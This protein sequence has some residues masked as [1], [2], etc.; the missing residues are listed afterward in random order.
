MAKRTAFAVLVILIWPAVVRAQASSQSA[1][2]LSAP[3]SYAEAL[4]VLDRLQKQ[5]LPPPHVRDVQQNRPLCL[6][7]LGRTDEAAAAGPALG[8]PGLPAERGL[9][10]SARAR[11]V[12]RG[13]RPPAAG[14]HRRALRGSADGLRRAAVG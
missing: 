3:A 8:V 5:P 6:L 14:D 2:P 7:A 9:H 13:A 4:A 11:D 10:A 12:Q 1:Q